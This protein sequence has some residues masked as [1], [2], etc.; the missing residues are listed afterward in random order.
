MGFEYGSGY[1]FWDK[2]EMYLVQG[3]YEYH[4]YFNE[5]VPEMENYDEV[6]DELMPTLT[7]E[8]VEFF[9]PAG[10]CSDTDLVW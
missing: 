6:M 3:L 9:M 10:I 7:V 2:A 8:K 1:S 5:K 4:V